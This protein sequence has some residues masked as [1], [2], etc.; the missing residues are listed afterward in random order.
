[1]VHRTVPWM[2]GLLW[3]G[4]RYSLSGFERMLR[5]NFKQSAP[6]DRSVREN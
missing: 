3:V 4:W 5:C 2:T 6:S 1:M